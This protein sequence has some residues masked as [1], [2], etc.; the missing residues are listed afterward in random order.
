MHPHVPCQVTGPRERL[1]AGLAYMWLLPRMCPHVLSQVAGIEECFAARLTYMRLL[2][3]MCP[4]VRSQLA[5]RRKRIAA[6]LA[7]EAALRATTSPFP[8]LLRCSTPRAAATSS[9]VRRA[10]CVVRAT[11]VVHVCRV[12]H[13]SHL[14]TTGNRVVTARALQPRP[15]RHGR[16][17]VS[18]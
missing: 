14:R 5:G 16:K 3:I 9:I 10:N 7:V 8:A 11:C 2:P 6:R 13:A 15:P 18:N 4:H 1:A 12:C 17:H